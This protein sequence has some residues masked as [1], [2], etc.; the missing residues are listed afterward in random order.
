MLARITTI[1]ARRVTRVSPIAI[2][3]YADQNSFNK[4]EKAH[5]DQYARTHEQAQLKKLREEIEAKRQ[6][7]ADLEKQHEAASKK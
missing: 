4:K 6:E 2:R 5:E 7:L 1:S 3:G